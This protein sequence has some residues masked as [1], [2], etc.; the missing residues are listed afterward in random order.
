MPS[1]PSSGSAVVPRY[2]LIQI[3]Y[4]KIYVHLRCYLQPACGSVKVCFLRGPGGGS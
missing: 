3:T 2:I 4:I 1:C